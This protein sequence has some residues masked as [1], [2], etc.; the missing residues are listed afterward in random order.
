MKQATTIILALA[1]T[2]LSACGGV[3]SQ[4]TLPPHQSP[5]DPERPPAAT[6]YVVSGMVQNTLGE[7]YV[8]VTVIATPEGEGA[9][10]STTTD[11]AG[12]YRLTLPRTT[13]AWTAQAHVLMSLGGDGMV[14]TWGPDE[15]QP[16]PGAGGAVRNIAVGIH[17]PLGS[18][19]PGVEHSGVEL[20]YE[21]LELT[22]TPAVP[23]VFGHTQPFTRRYVEG[24][25]IRNVPLGLYYVTAT[26]VLQ[27][28]VQELM[29]RQ[30]TGIGI[31][32]PAPASTRYLA[33][34]NTR[35]VMGLFLSQGE[36]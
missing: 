2:T 31:K 25:G 23:N 30:M 12:R 1:L 16:F 35:D 14:V 13:Q 28:E 17:Q 8:G 15:F 11:V 5:Q 29:I 9:L 24:E 19:D 6:P 20:D 27:G 26:Q 7:P 22:F 33:G 4:P 32:P 21:T 36:D 18:V 10:V 3:A 34:F